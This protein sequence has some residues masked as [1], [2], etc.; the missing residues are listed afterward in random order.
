MKT[1]PPATALRLSLLL[2]SAALLSQCSSFQPRLHT[3]AAPLHPDEV[4]VSVKDQKLGLYEHGVLKKKY[5][6]ST[7]KFGLGSA[8]GSCKTPLGHLEIADKIGAGLP[9]GAVLKARAWNG[10][11]LT[12]NAPGR[13]PVVS[14]ILWLRGLESSNRNTEQ[15]LIYIHGTPEERN[16]GRP[17]SYGCV[18]MGMKDVITVFEELAVGTTVMITE[19]RLCRRLAAEHEEA[20]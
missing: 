8:P 15:R 5:T 6:I 9:A 18:R 16:L 17:A 1:L 14:R 10:E 3:T 11:V 7:S 13:D 2:V 20:Q 4:I 19:N 12:P